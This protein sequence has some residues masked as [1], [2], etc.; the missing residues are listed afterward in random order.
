M[1]VVYARSN[2]ALDDEFIDD[3]GTLQFPAL[4]IGDGEPGDESLP[5]G[6]GL[7]YLRRVR[8]QHRQYQY[9]SRDRRHCRG[10]GC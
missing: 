6:D 3:E 9:R 7:E 10:W 1:S 8:K 4:P 5:P 2:N